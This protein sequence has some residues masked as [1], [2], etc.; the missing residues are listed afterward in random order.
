MREIQKDAKSGDSDAQLTFN[1][2]IYQ[3]IKYIGSYSAVLG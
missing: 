3:I 1:A 2:Y